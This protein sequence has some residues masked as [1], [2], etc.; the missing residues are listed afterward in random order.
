LTCSRA[1]FDRAYAGNE[2]L[3]KAAK[4]LFGEKVLV[5]IVEE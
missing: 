1:D 2:E 5:A 4:G 3:N